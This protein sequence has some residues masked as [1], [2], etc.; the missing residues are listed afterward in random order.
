MPPPSGKAYFGGITKVEGEP[1]PATIRVH[2]RPEEGAAGDGTVV[3]TTQSRPDGTWMVEGLNPA[4]KYD[5]VGRK[6]GHND[7]IMADVS[8][9]V[10]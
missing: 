7:V 10:E 9:E 4:L 2:Y 8:P 1:A 6:S 5:A 3:A